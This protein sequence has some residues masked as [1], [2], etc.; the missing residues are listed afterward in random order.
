MSRPGRLTVAY[1]V[2]PLA[3]GTTGV[4]RYVGRLDDALGALDPPVERHRF[5]LGRA[6]HDLPAGT[7]RVTVPLRALHR[8]WSA[9]RWPPIER[10]VG[11][12][13]LVHATDLVPPPTAR[14]LVLTVHDL[15]AVLHPDLHSARARRQQ[16]A[17]LEAARRRADAVIADSEATAEVL[18]R[19]GVDAGK[20]TV[21]AL[22]TT[23]LPA[24]DHRRVPD[25]PYLLFVGT[26]D[27]R[28][29][30]DVLLAAFDAAALG[31]VDLLLA[32][33]DQHGAGAIRA[34][35]AA[36]PG[37]TLLGRVT[38]AELAGLYDRALAVCLPSRAEGF[39]LTVLEA[40]AA[41]A[42]IV[43][44]DLPVLREVGGDDVVYV[45]TGDVDAWSTALTGIVGDGAHRARLAAAGPPRAATFTWQRTAERT[46]AVYE[47][48]LAGRS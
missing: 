35:A 3:T 12:C 8:W 36:A 44:S 14:P 4:A 29:G 37:V 42:P 26:V 48:V 20:V 23:P 27:A 28:K 34:R 2:T 7:R 43:A 21:V 18:R 33:P 16:V 32:G 5:A 39:G 46:A 45:P 22:G 9:V 31:D 11:P 15:D 38:D 30:L 41:G 17:Q 24:P 6:H 25:R 1:D 13:D 10:L 47:S 40:M 19:Q